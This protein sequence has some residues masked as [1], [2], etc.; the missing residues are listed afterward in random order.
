[1]LLV[2]GVCTKP[3]LQFAVQSRVGESTC[4]SSSSAC[5]A[6]VSLSIWSH[7]QHILLPWCRISLQRAYPS[8]VLLMFIVEHTS[9]RLD[10]TV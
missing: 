8:V 1:M 5:S 10:T 9:T 6:V 3:G 4:A 7:K 2:L